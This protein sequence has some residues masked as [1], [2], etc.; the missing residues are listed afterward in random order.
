[1]SDRY[2]AHHGIL[3]MQWGK[4]NGPPYPLSDDAH[5][6]KERKRGWKRSL[7]TD[8]KK[9][10]GKA[11]VIAG[12]AAIGAVSLYALYKSDQNG[13]ADASAIFNYLNNATDA[14]KNSDEYRNISKAA[15]D[16]ANRYAKRYT[17]E[18]I[19]DAR[20]ADRAMKKELRGVR[21]EERKKKVKAAVDIAKVGYNKAKDAHEKVKTATKKVIKTGKKAINTGKKI[22][23]DVDRFVNRRVRPQPAGRLGRYTVRDYRDYLE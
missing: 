6:A 10:I 15:N 21:K 11:A 13:Y 12:V 17:R 2:L 9:K 7:D 4:R 14:D 16:V 1:M 8:T 18:Q 19:R 3:G 20:A 23:Q 5:S 22:K